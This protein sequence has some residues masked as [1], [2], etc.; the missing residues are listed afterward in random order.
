[1]QETEKMVDVICMEFQHSAEEGEDSSNASKEH[2]STTT[3]PDASSKDESSE[4]EVQQLLNDQQQFEDD[5]HEAMQEEA[6][7]QDD[8]DSDHGT[9][10]E[11]PP[12]AE[13]QSYEA[14]SDNNTSDESYDYHTDNDNSSIEGSDDESSNTVPGLQKKS[15]TDRRSDENSVYRQDHDREHMPATKHQ[16]VLQSINTR[17][18]V[19]A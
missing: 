19:H 11:V 10:T 1:M 13:R 3:I 2:S 16:S 4:A 6:T 9:D 15:C 14:S 17:P 12:L 7:Q 18:I 8:D 5:I